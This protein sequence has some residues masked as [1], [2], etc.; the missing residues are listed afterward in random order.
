VRATLLH[1]CPTP[2][3]LLLPRPG[4][5][6]FL[7]PFKGKKKQQTVWDAVWIDAASE[8]AACSTN[9]PACLPDWLA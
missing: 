6:V 2:A 9:L 5:L 1:Q 8:R 3:S 4:K 7:R